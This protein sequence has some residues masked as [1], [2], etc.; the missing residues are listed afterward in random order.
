MAGEDVERRLAAILCA[1]VVGYSRLV[2][3]DEIGTLARL[4]AHRDTL[5]DRMIATHKGRIVKE[6]GDGLL[7]EFSTVVEAVQCA[8]GIQSEMVTQNA[9]VSEHQR[10]VF[11][12]GINVGDVIVTGDDILGDG[13][14][15][16]A[17]LEALAPPGSI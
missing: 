15:V 5:I 7:V 3:A 1:G 14:N 16:A 8:V 13:V 17:R 2:E 6:M 9:G 10:I 12:I 11:R 4:E